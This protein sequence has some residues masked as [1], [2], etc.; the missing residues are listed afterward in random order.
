[1]AGRFVTIWLPDFKTDWL[2]VRNPELR[3]IPFVLAAPDHGRMIIT[4][5]NHMARL[6]GIDAGMVLADAR[7]IF[8]QLRFMDDNPEFFSNLLERMAEWCIRFSPLV[9]VDAPDGIILDALGCSHL[10]GGEEQYLH[11]ITSRFN[12]FGYQLRIAMADTIGAAWA[13]ARFRKNGSIIEPG[14]QLT[15]LLALPV[16][17]LRLEPVVL[18]RLI[19]LGLRYIKDLAE[20]PRSAL[21][22]RFGVELIK[23]INQ[24]FGKETESMVPVQPPSPFIERL[25]CL[26]PI[27]TA[28]G[29]EIAIRRLLE[30]LCNRLK[31]EEKGIRQ[32]S[33]KGYRIDG[34]LEKIEIG[35]SRPSHNEAH[36]FKLFELKL[37]N[38]E[39]ALGIELFTLES[40]AVEDL[41]AA[42]ETIWSGAGGLE[43]NAVAELL[44]RIS[45]Q[46]GSEHISRYLPDEH[47]W[48]ERSIKAA[49]HLQEKPAKPWRTDQPRPTQIL[50]K[51]EPV[52]VTA[53]IPDYPPM[54]FR[55][56]G[57]LH[58]I[59]KADGPERIEHE[60]WLEKG[61]H[62]DYYCV[63]DE[64]G[65]RYWLFRSGHYSSESSYQWFMHGFFA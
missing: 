56:R 24:A 30:T 7:A 45:N 27:C 41:P 19:K 46:L 14:M 38:I 61:L 39:P 11:E 1:M 10:S 50:L 63:E 51:P 25:P 40:N 60:W 21:K 2:S 8:P 52:Q 59:I 64:E 9:A 5:S 55:Y 58:K 36:L 23:R 15:S 4:A 3:K 20:M 22:R 33:F 62:R 34:K 43:N 29:I 32:A 47:Y 54:L 28:T 12:R 26:E 31:K 13:H 65:K 57:R 6:Q 53:P 48:P 17:A 35:T 18:E 44:D 16:T 49:N 37:N 42:Q